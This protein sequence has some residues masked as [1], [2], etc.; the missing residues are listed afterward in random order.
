MLIKT[1][2]SQVANPF[3][4]SPRRKRPANLPPELTDRERRIIE[5]ITHPV[6]VMDGEFLFKE[7][8]IDDELFL[9]D[10]GKVAL[11][12]LTD[13]CSWVNM[14]PYGPVDVEGEEEARWNTVLVLGPGDV[15]GEFTLLGH[16]AHT[17]SA[18]VRQEGDLLELDAPHLTWLD[19]KQPGV[20]RHLM[21]ALRRE[22]NW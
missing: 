13:C 19:Q 6:H 12:H 7:G 2:S 21:E 17:L 15:V 18:M 16:S 11:G 20:T 14:G 5:E 1:K 22:Y 8:E 3:P 9:I 10:A 4:G